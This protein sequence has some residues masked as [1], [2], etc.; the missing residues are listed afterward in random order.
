[1]SEQQCGCK[2]SRVSKK[3]KIDGLNEELVHLWTA[4][5]EDRYSTRQLSDYINKEILEAALT[6]AGIQYKSGEIENTYRLLTD[7]NVSSGARIQTR[8][9]L[10]KDSIPIDTIENDF[11]SHQSVYNHLT[12]C[13][14]ASIREPSSSERLERSKDSLGAL[15]NRVLAVTT[16]TVD[17]LKKNKSLEIGDFNVLVNITVICEDCQRQYTVRELL[18]RGTCDCSIE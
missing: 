11:V 15:Q 8:N 7:D 4:Q 1:M 6:Q 17:R 14:D 13:L 10:E 2:I 18:D 16:D 12:D 5:D 3:Y 9:E